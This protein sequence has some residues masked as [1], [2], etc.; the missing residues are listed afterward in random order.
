MKIREETLQHLAS[1]LIR[2]NLLRLVM[3]KDQP[4]DKGKIDNF[5]FLFLKLALYNLFYTKE[6]LIKHYS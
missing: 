4:D 1:Y 5:L 6:T 2:K 3:V